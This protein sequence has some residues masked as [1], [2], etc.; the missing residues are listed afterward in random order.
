VDNGQ[1]KDALN[2]FNRKLSM[3]PSAPDK[4]E[5]YYDMA[6]AYKKLEQYKMALEYA[7]KAKNGGLKLDDSFMNDLEK[8]AKSSQ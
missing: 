2:D 3:D 4:P 8:L 6:I 1:E 7:N 5:C